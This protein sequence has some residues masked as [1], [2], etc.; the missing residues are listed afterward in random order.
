MNLSAECKTPCIARP[1]ALVRAEY[2]KLTQE[3]GGNEDAA[4]RTYLVVMMCIC[5]NAK[6]DKVL[7]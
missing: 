5:P 7:S 2:V 4:F 6:K 1:R 3:K